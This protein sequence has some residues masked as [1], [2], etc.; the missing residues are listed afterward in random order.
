MPAV[1]Q[2]MHR[3]DHIRGIVKRVKE[4]LLGLLEGPPSK[5]E[6]RLLATL[7]SR[8]PKLGDTL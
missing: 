6:V 3:P 2:K 7:V 1:Y 5:E 4:D 8:S